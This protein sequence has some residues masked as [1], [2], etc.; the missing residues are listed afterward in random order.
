[1]RRATRARRI[2]WQRHVLERMAERD[3][4]RS[5]V[6]QVL[7]GGERIE[8]Y[9]ETKPFPSALFLGWSGP[10]PLHVVAAYDSSGDR[11]FIITAYEPDLEHFEPGF[12]IRRK[13]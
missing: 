12:K 2:D 10:R 7:L 9:P 13:P 5:E 11:V 4:G 6:F 1:M 3:I 8:D